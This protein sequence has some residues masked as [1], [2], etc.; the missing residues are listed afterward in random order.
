M[1][2]VIGL[3]EDIQHANG[4]V[5]ALSDA[6]I[7]PRHINIV[8][9]DPEERQAGQL[10]QGAAKD[11]GEVATGGAVAGGVLGGTAGALLGLGAFAIPGLGPVIAAGPL[12]AGLVGAGIGAASGGVIGALVDWG[13][14]EEEAEFYLE[15]VRRGGVLV[16]VR[17]PEDRVDLI[18]ERMEREGLVDLEERV[19]AWRE[20]GWHG[21]DAGEYDDLDFDTYDRAFR[22]HYESNFAGTQEP[23]TNYTPAYRFGYFLATEDRFVNRNWSEMEPE[24]R[25]VWEQEHDEPWEEYKGAIQFSW[26]R[27]QMKTL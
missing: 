14:S 3:Y 10:A 16:A 26:Q 25:R 21:Y 12:V 13:V 18:V 19:E 27:A 4:A 8:A 24:A 11:T 20:E 5:Q 6:G 15:G 7:D 23:Y 22:A 2:T 17:A 9:G 1:K